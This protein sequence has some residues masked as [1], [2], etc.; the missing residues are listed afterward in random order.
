MHVLMTGDHEQRRA[1]RTPIK[2]KSCDTTQPAAIKG[3]A[4][5]RTSPLVSEL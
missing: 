2:P 4:G 3:W 5:I 1:Q